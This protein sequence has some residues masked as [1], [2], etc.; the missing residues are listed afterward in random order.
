[1]SGYVVANYDITN[2]EGYQAY[3]ETVMPTLAAHGAEILAADYESEVREGSPGRVT[4]VI[5]F[6]S[7]SAAQ[8]WYESPEYQAIVHHRTDN[9]EG[10]LVICEERR[11]P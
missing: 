5:R 6:E 9:S 1:M 10:S 8:G 4:I 7:A 2:Q 11:R 3:I